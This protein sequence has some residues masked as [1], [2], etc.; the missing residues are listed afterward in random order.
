MLQQLDRES[1]RKQFASA[2]PFPYVKIEKFLDPAFAIEIAGAYPS[3]EHATTHGRSFKALNEKRKVQITDS[4]L[5]PSTIAQLN[6]A[7]SGQAFLSDLSYVTGIPDLLPD[8]DL[9]GGG[10]HISGPGG[11]LDV[12]VDF[13][14]MEQRK[15]YRR[16]NLLLYLNPVWEKPWGGEI[17]LW[18]K[19]VQ[20]CRQAFAPALNRCIIFE[21]SDISFHG[22][23]PI[24]KAAPFPRI[25][26][27]SYY[28]TLQAP[29]GWNGTVHSTVFKARPDERLR[30]Y[31][32]MPI[33]SVK[34]RLRSNVRRLKGGL[35]QLL[36]GSH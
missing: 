31:V 30:R 15:L 16:L 28:Y 12:H 18:D 29:S 24:S 35:K 1:L 26:F 9:V 14:Y 8:A 27:A 6:E 10:M 32:L 13:N 23:T 7:L 25:S 36:G 33:E 5:F 3:F 11:R 20:N 17:Q 19:D 21:T 22:V 4:K 34:L 2:K